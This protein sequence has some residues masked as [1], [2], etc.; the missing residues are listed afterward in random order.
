LIFLNKHLNKNSTK[1]TVSYKLKRI[2]QKKHNHDR[3][4]NTTEAQTHNHDRQNNTN[5]AQT[6]IMID[7]A[8]LM[9][10]KHTITIDKTTLLKH[11]PQS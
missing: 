11:K 8:T 6:T 7:K 4:N 1:K 10:H 3:Q 5:E 2:V 9:K